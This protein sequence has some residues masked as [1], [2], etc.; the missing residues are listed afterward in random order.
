V[1]HIEQICEKLLVTLRTIYKIWQINLFFIIQRDVL[2][3]NPKFDYKATKS[4]LIFSPGGWFEE[5]NRINKI[6][7]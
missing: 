6:Y 2:L 1:G 4:P 5:K 7:K 3:F